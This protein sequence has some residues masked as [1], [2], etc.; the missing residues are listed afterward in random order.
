[1]EAVFA[2]DRNRLLTLVIVR[3]SRIEQPG[4]LVLGFAGNQHPTLSAP[5][6]TLR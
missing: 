1:M 5:V 6:L 4:G 2:R 3:E